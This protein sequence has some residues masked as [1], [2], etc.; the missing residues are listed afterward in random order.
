[1]KPTTS[2]TTTPTTTPTQ[3]VCA[4]DFLRCSGR[5][6]Q[7]ESAITFGGENSYVNGDIGIAPGTSITG[8]YIPGHNGMTYIND[9][10][11]ASCAADMKTIVAQAAGLSCTSIAAELGERRLQLIAS[12]RC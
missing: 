4:V 6:L 8:E 12:I 11:S 2:P 5:V 10:Y 1:M 9:A 7:A 3:K